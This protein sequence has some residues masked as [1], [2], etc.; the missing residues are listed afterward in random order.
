MKALQKDFLLI[1]ESYGR[2]VVD[3]TLAR[4]Y[5]KKLLENSRVVGFLSSKHRE[6]LPELQRIVEVAALET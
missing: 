1:E 5:L 6:L 4:G 2:N 3:L